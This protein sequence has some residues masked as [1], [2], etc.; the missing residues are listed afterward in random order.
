ML[1]AIRGEPELAASIARAAASS[2]EAAAIAELLRWSAAAPENGGPG[3]G[4]TPAAVV[5]CGTSENAAMAAALL[6]QDAWRR[7]GLPGPWPV[8]RQAFEAALEPW[9]GATVAISHEGGTAATN[10]ALRSARP[11]GGRTGLITAAANSPGAALADTCL[12]TGRLDPSW[13]HTIGY[14]S[15]VVASAAVG[16]ALT[17]TNLDEA[18]LDRLVA[19]GLEQ[20]GVAADLGRSLAGLASLVVTAS[21]ADRP[22]GREMTLKVEEA[23]YVPTRY[24]DLETM[25]HGHLPS[26]DGKTGVVLILTDRASLASRAR[27]A[28]QLLEALVAIGAQSGA[29]LSEGAAAAIPARLTPLGR[30]VVPEAPDLPGPVAAL[31]GS[32][33]PLQLSTYAVALA[34]GTNPDGLR[35]ESEAYRAA[36]AVAE[37][38]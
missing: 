3:G 14:L 5:G 28:C 4:P 12:C 37:A 16:A 1:D 30:I 11:A 17:G 23:S 38:G 34:R 7:A 26:M 31:V 36:A 27:R 19:A 9:S 25:L 32:A 24:R 18:E 20:A 13:C 10:D 6:W 35:R 33:V 21:G 22:A 29:I 2:G 15:P 8:A